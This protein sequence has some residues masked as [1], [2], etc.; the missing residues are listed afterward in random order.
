MTLILDE[1][2]NQIINDTMA[3]V[4]T[5]RGV[6]DLMEDRLREIIGEAVNAGVRHGYEEGF[7][8]GLIWGARLGGQC[9]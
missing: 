4:P 8:Q 6:T 5:V 1:I 9:V 7:G 3:Q 2:V